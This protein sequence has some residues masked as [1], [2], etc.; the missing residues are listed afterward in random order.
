MPKIASDH[1]LLSSQELVVKVV[2]K[3]PKMM[4]YL[5]CQLSL[6]S[7]VMLCQTRTLIS[8]LSFRF[9]QQSL[10]HS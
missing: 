10:F 4:A 7:Q 1:V 9:T 8:A 5:P 6:R 3:V 2:N